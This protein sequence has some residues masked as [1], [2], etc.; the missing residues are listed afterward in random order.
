[1]GKNP[2]FS[3]DYGISRGIVYFID[4]VHEYICNKEKAYDDN[5]IIDYFFNIKICHETS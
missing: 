1:M 2:V 5:Y 3:E 4:L